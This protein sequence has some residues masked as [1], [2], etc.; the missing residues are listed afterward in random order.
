M[1]GRNDLSIK[2]SRKR[3]CKLMEEKHIDDCD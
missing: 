1:D 3:I 2:T